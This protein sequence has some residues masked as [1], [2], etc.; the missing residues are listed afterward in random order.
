MKRE[1][2]YEVINDF[3][4]RRIRGGGPFKDVKEARRVKREHMEKHPYANVF[5][6][7][8]WKEDGRWFGE[9]MG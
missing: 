9:A 1:Y 6:Y 7:K 2:E 4:A 8:S 5:I 3:V